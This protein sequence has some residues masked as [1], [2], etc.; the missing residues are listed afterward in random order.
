MDGIETLRAIRSFEKEI[1]LIDKVAVVFISRDFDFELRQQVMQE[2]TKEF[3][4]KPV[5]RS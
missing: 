5:S 2:G 4:V 3:L 1:K